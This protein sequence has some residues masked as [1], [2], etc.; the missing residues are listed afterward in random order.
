MKTDRLKGHMLSN[1]KEIERL[2]TR[3]GEAVKHRDK[4]PKEKVAWEAA[5]R[6]F[7][8]RYDALAFPGGYSD[9]LVRVASGDAAAIEAALC[10]LELRPRFFRS[11]YIYKDIFRK[12]KRAQLSERQ[13]SRLAQVQKDN[14]AYRAGSGGGPN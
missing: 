5:C 11:G 12:I 7:H 9:A 6:E 3:I 2:R 14:E 4:G 13:A 8:E 1:A 10:F